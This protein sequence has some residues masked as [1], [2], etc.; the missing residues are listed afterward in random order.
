MIGAQVLHNELEKT[1]KLIT[2]NTTTNMHVFNHEEKLKKYDKVTDI[3]DDFFV[4]R[5]H[6][7]CKRKEAMIRY[8][9]KEL[10]LITNKAKFINENVNGT[11][12]LIRKKKSEIIELLKSKE[13]DIIDGDDT[14]NY[15]TKMP[16]DS[17]IEENVAKLNKEQGDKECELT[18]IRATSESQMWLNDI[19]KLEAEYTKYIERRYIEKS[20]KT[21]KKKKVKKLVLSS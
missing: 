9:T 17:M 6:L 18:T 10:K 5:M 21:P 15:L 7:Y 20:K 4:H 2:T 13:Y 19:E 8:V 14:Y 12:V 3:I 16:M 1:L 11:I